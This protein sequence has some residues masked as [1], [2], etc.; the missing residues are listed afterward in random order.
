MT[1]ESSEAVAERFIEALL[2]R[3]ER[4]AIFPSRGSPR[5]D[6]GAGVRTA[7]DK[8]SVVIVYRVRKEVVTVV[9]FFYRGRGVAEGTYSRQ[10]RFDVRAREVF[11]DE[12]QRASELI[13]QRIGEAIAEIQA[14]GVEALPISAIG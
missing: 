12:E 5:G 9:G 14:G 13:R 1:V 10:R 6:L 8:R 2:A 4:L 3:C 7:V 11:A